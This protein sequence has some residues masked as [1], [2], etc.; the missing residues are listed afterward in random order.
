MSIYEME[1]HIYKLERENK[2]LRDELAGLYPFH[3]IHNNESGLERADCDESV[4]ETYFRLIIESPVFEWIK[5]N[6][7][8]AMFL[9]EL[10]QQ[11]I[12]WVQEQHNI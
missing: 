11:C 5:A 1:A 8:P 2:E 12:S 9:L 6:D 4:E 7:D 3:P 10:A